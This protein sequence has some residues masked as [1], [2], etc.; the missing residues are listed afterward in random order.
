MKKFTQILGL[1]GVVGLAVGV[2]ALLVGRRLNIFIE[3]QLVIGSALMLFGIATNLGPLKEYLFK[4]AG[5]AQTDAMLQ[6]LGLLVIFLLAGIIIYQHNW[7]ADVTKNA[8][9]TLTPKTKQLLKNLPGPIT[10]TAFLPGEGSDEVRE[11]L[12]LFGTED[13]KLKIE[14]IDP[15]SH[16]ERAELKNVSAYETVILEYQGREARVIQPTEEDLIN[17]LIRVTRDTSPVICFSTGHAEADPE[18]QD[19]GGLSMLKDY[20]EQENFKIRKILLTAEGIPEDCRLL[21]VAGP[22]G[23]F[24]DWEV[25]AID[26]YMGKGGDAIILVD[27]FVFTNLENLMAGLG[28]ELRTGVVVDPEN[29]MVG[30]DSVGLSP[31]ASKFGNHEITTELQGKLVA[32][33][34]VRPLGILDKP[35][36]QG[37]WTPLVYSSDKSYVETD[38]EGLYKYGRTSKTPDKP[39]GTQLLAAAYD[40]TEVLKPWQALESKH[41]RETRVVVVGNSHFMRNLALEVYSNYVFATNIFNWT[42]GENEYVP[43]PIKRRSASRVY[44]TEHQI[45]IIFYN[46]VLV[47][48]EILAIIGIAVWWR[49]K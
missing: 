4:R 38:Y 23:P 12:K 20:L 11:V 6:V 31:V 36:L 34:R 39:S 33:P 32:F 29:Y 24:Q 41:S 16:P 13:K 18:V 46:S 5:R 15:D 7:M 40:E 48:P 42:A 8:L 2:F 14:I 10:V 17:S 19:K 27:P 3:L 21:V 1:I 28:L 37:R 44:L 49:R 30:M 26:R 43:I 25:A 9:Y 45:N 22:R 47:I 35:D